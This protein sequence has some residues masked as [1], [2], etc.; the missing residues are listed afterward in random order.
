[1]KL[2]QGDIRYEQSNLK[3]FVREESGIATPC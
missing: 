1:M 2:S 3:Q